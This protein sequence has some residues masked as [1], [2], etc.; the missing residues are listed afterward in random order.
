V[1]LACQNCGAALVVGER[2]RTTKC[3]YCASP[4][5]VQRPATADRPHP[6]FTIPFAL[7]EG[8]AR[9]LVRGWLKTRGFFRD[10]KLKTAAITDLRGVYVP[11]Y[12]YAAVAHSSYS[13]K[14]GEDYTETET[15]TETDSNGNTQTKTRTVTRTEWRRL[16][17]AHASYVMDVLVT[18]SR[19]LR[20]DEL[21]AIEPFDL[22]QVRRHDD[23]LLAGWVAE[24][25]TLAP[26]ECL[27]AARAEAMQKIGAELDRFM[28]GDSHQGLQYQTRLEHETADAMYV[29]VWVLAAAHDPSKPP[30]R[31]VVNGQSGAV[32]GLAPLSALRIALAVAVAVL[33]V[34]LP[35][36]LASLGGRR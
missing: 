36:V 1:D 26:E 21:E 31:V 19:G 3:P 33:A 32:H 14:I 9:E 12:L 7:G 5:I 27:R 22:R 11:A 8:P 10:P 24:E 16:S 15:Y 28:P 34:A 25:P 20:D 35:F 4:Q 23:A 30:L 2:E 17:G 13:A 6:T 29:P 18:A